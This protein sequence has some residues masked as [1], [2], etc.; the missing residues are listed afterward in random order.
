MPG[1]EQGLVD[2]RELLAA[3]V[4]AFTAHRSAR[5]ID[6]PT[7]QSGHSVARTAPVA[8]EHPLVAPHFAQEHFAAVPDFGV[9][10]ERVIDVAG[11]DLEPPHIALLSLPRH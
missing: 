1:T 7:V 4:T 9:G 2:A 5:Q 8:V 10:V 6:R 3:V 11:F